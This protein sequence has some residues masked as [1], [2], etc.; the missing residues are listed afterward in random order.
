MLLVRAINPNGKLVQEF[1]I[2]IF[3]HYP[4]EVPQCTNTVFNISSLQRLPL[5]ISW[6]WGFPS[7]FGI[8]ASYFQK[9]KIRLVFSFPNGFEI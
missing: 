8:L 6:E 3:K 2:Q 5:K 7:N 9:L 4:I 1:I